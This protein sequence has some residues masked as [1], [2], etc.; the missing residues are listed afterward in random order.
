MRTRL[1]VALLCLS[2]VAMAAPPDADARRA[3]Y[4]EG[5]RALVAKDWAG[6]ETI[7]KKLWVEGATY[8]VALSLGQAEFRQ[9]KYRDAAEHLE[10]A[11]ANYPPREKTDTLERAKKFL[12]LAAKQVGTLHITVDQK[13]AQMLIDGEPIGTSP[14]PGNTYVDAGAHTVEA[15]LADHAPARQEI[16]V[17]AGASANVELKFT[18]PVL[19]TGIE[20]AGPAP[21]VG[22]GLD[23]QNPTANPPAETQKRGVEART[24]ALWSGVGV[25]AVALGVGVGFAFKASAASD[26]FK[27]LDS[28][29]GPNDCSA[30]AAPACADLQKALDDRNAAN[31]VKNV[32]FVVA[33]VAA[34]ATA[35][36]FF[37]WP[38]RRGGTARELRVLPIATQNTG[39]LLINGNF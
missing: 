10:Y 15:R 39:G 33:G 29:L 31:R 1:I 6:A 24:V 11:I 38:S 14:L 32:S 9:N 21:A 5:D 26:D 36:M 19:L 34:V 28:T 17:T 8:D 35:S 23:G 30:P 2:S 4:L 22:A 20:T 12:S 27:S 3:A 37:L 7:F 16:S 13:G 25:T 18:G